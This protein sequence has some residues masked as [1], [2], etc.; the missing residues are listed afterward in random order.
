MTFLII[1]GGIA[2]PVTAMAL[3]EAGIDSTVFEAYQNTADGVG[4]FLGLAPNGLR[5]LRVLGLDK[6]IQAEG[7]ESPDIRLS[8]SGGRRLLEI[9][10]AGT[11]PDAPTPITL[12]RADL[13]RA[14]RD[15]AERRG[16]P[17]EYG[18]RLIDAETHD[19]VVTAR[20]DDGSTATGDALIGADG[21][22]SRVRTIIDPNAPA[23]RYVPYLNTGGYAEGV[24]VQTPVGTA[25]MIFGK[26]AFF[27]YTPSPD[28]SVWWFAN[29]PQRTELDRTAL[30]AIGP[31]EWRKR[32]L[33]LFADDDP[34]INDLINA[35]P[36]IAPCWST[37]D[38]PNVPTWH[39]NQMSIIGDAA[40]ATA[41]SAGQGASMAMEDAIELAR[42]LR[43]IPETSKAFAAYESLRRDR[44]ERVV[45]QGKRNGSGKA[46][47][48]LGRMMLP[49]VFRFMPTPDLNWIY[50]YEPRW[51]ER[52]G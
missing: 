37:Y 1:G 36:A 16:I 28:G 44:V 25:Q 2:G 33:T 3:Q 40:H 11:N 30:A 51:E 48:V 34:L 47:G 8:L 18:K 38:Y 4:A 45:A 43:D 35:T 52:V 32:L 5:A 29:P 13:Y 31:E 14:L 7:F 17:F 27:G 20:F 21:L 22:Q 19:G 23:P 50:D 6:L 41:P 42:C 26:R 10:M 9:S 12:K 39:K 15:E 46:P 49:V 24:K